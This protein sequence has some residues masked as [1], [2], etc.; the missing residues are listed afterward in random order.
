[1]MAGGCR[2]GTA[3]SDPRGG[4]DDLKLWPRVGGW[5]GCMPLISAP[6]PKSAKAKQHWWRISIGRLSLDLRVNS[7][8]TCVSG[9]IAAMPPP[10]QS[11]TR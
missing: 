4:T 5:G 6:T 8:G 9:S 1:M 3:A 7:G 2:R 10:P 11:N